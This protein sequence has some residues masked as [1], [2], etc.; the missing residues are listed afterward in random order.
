MNGAMPSESEPSSHDIPALP[1]GF[2]H[3]PIWRRSVLL[4]PCTVLSL[5]W[6]L[7]A[8]L[9]EMKLSRLF[10]YGLPEII[11]A[12]SYILLPFYLTGL[13]CAAV[14]GVVRRSRPAV[15]PPNSVLNVQRQWHR[16]T[17]LFA[18]WAACSAFEV[19]MFQGT[20]LYWKLTGSSKT[21]FDFGFSTLHGCLNSLILAL[22]LCSFYLYRTTHRNKFLLIPATCAFW[23]V[24][25]ISRQVL[26]VEIIELAI[27][28]FATARWTF[29]FWA[30][31]SGAAL[32]TL[33]VFGVVG[34]LRSGAENFRKLA[35]TD[36][37]PTWLPS[38]FLWVYMYIATPLNNLLHTLAHGVVSPEPTLKETAW[39]LFPTVIRNR[40]F[41]DTVPPIGGLLVSDV[42]TVCSV[43]A[44][45]YLD[46]GLN[47]IVIF[48]VF[49]SGFCH[50]FWQKRSVC[51]FL[52]YAI[53]AQCL[54]LTVFF[55][56][57]FYLPVIAQLFWV[58]I[59]FH[60]GEHSMSPVATRCE[61][62]AGDALPASS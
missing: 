2:A 36:D 44:Q 27:V 7:S 56:H 3:A 10:L 1:S 39:L 58:F 53:L 29:M 60:R 49:I 52:I 21:Y 41:A 54:A 50:F 8:A 43:Y 18:C 45:P 4:H 57:F 31:V 9:Y 47:G 30:R 34:D 42:F 61:T 51:S 22:A 40:L 26:I 12:L 13:L 6:F 46:L 15:G 32:A 48:S 35:M 23:T 38:G 59:I 33:L 28:F 14:F 19:V 5:A 24:L 37:F 55:N 16:I 17:W 25:V 62:V 20:P 11:V